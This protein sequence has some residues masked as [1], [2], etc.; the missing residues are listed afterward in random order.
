MKEQGDECHIVNTASIAGIVASPEL[1]AY[2]VTKYGVVA[3]TEALYHELG[4]SKSKIKV[5][6]V[7]PSYVRTRIVD[8]VRN[9]PG[10]SD[11]PTPR[12]SEKEINEIWD[13]LGKR[14]NSPAISPEVVADCIFKA[15]KAE[16]LYVIT[17]PESKVWIRN[18]MENI[19]EE[20]NPEIM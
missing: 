8:C 10:A 12:L 6:V 15:I 13:G 1:G 2:C 3:L 11:A 7:C 20:R 14:D 17:H 16:K 4:R 18:R 9:R 5:S 19:L